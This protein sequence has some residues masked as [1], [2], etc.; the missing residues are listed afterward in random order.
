MSIESIISMLSKREKNTADHDCAVRFRSRT[1]GVSDDERESVLLRLS[2]RV[3]SFHNV[4]AETRS[5]IMLLVRAVLSGKLKHLESIVKS[6]AAQASQLGEDM[7]ILAYVFEQQEI[8]FLETTVYKFDGENKNLPL[9]A[10]LCIEHRRAKRV[11]CIST[12]PEIETVAFQA[13]RRETGRISL[14]PAESD[15]ASSLHANIAAAAI[16]TKEAR[17]SPWRIAAAL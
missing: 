5:R 17:V 6:Y 4:S 16:K 3:N 10:N 8:V 13:F 15:E 9:A 1:T 7:P 12:H 2:A 11:L 14:I